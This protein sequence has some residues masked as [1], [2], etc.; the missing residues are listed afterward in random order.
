MEKTK[1]IPGWYQRLSSHHS[2]SAAQVSFKQYCQENET[3]MKILYPF[4]PLEQL[5][6]KLL[7]R[8]KKKQPRE[9]DNLAR[10]GVKKQKKS[11][12][13]ACVHFLPRNDAATRVFSKDCA[14]SVDWLKRT[15][16]FKFAEG[17]GKTYRGRAFVLPPKV[18]GVICEAPGV[19]KGILKNGG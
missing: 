17:D 6:G 10:S 1:A 8:W 2:R 19:E 9:R 14:E 7:A 3:R 15:R 4:L 5:R 12:K 18:P 11:L 16:V 13:P